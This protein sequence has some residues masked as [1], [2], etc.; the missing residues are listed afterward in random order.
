MR[1][2]AVVA[3][4]LL[5]SSCIEVD[6]QADKKENKKNNNTTDTVGMLDLERYETTSDGDGYFDVEVVVDSGVSAFQVTG[7]SERYVSVEEVLDPSGQRVL[8]WEDLWNSTNALT[9][10]VFGYGGTTAFN[11]PIRASDGPLEDGTWR[12]RMSLVD[13]RTRY[14]GNEAVEVSVATKT[15]DDFQDASV[16]V[17]IVWADGVDSDP[18]AVEAVEAAVARWKDVWGA[19]GLTLDE[20]YVAST[21]DPNLNWVADYFGDAAVEAVAEGKAPGAL[22]LI[23]G[24]Q[25]RQSDFVYGIAA[26]IPGTIEVSPASYV[27]ISLVVH[28]GTD[29]AFDDGEIGLMGET[30][31]HEVGHYTGLYHPVEDGFESWD[32]LSDTAQCTQ[33]RDCED[34]LGTNLMF[35]YSI[36]DQSGCVVTEDLTPGQSGVMQRY[37]GAL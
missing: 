24:E 16:G 33:R 15:D 25:I 1:V 4:A 20:T 12:V 34:E 27:V 22:Q 11:W 14:V 13:D 10:A 37:L 29:G 35:P 36:C 6:P 23:V 2:A 3:G 30:M 19:Q 7:I 31:A 18:E 5:V 8:Y 28:A 32:A 26:G 17:Q 21:L 9:D